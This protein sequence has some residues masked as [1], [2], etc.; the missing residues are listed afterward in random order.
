M[1]TP[2][3]RTRLEPT[4]ALI[5]IVFLMLIFFMIAGTLS[6]PLDPDV[7]LV[8]T[9]EL[10]GREPSYAIVITAEGQLRYRGAEVET[11]A[12]YLAEHDFEAPGAP[13]I[14]RI[15]PDRE[16]P[17]TVLLAVA[18]ELRAGG[19]ERVMIVTENALP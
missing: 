6:P 8:D 11:A 9:R 2:R 16:A 7:S 14:A 19:A 5:N 18:R 4:I 15:L 1:R 10:E 13:K 12:S 3:K 17:A